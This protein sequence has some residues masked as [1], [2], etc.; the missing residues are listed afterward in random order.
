MRT[1]AIWALNAP[2]SATRFVNTEYASLLSL[3]WQG[4]SPQL[5]GL[6]NDHPRRPA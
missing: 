6:N 4:D 3:R 1:L 2:L 5:I